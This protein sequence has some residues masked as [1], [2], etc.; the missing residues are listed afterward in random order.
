MAFRE[1]LNHADDLLIKQNLLVGHDSVVVV[2]TEVPFA[3][4]Y[5]VTNLL[6]V[7]RGGVRF[8]EEAERVELT[9]RGGGTAMRHDEI[10]RVVMGSEV[11]KALR[12]LFLGR[13][14]LRPPRHVVDTERESAAASLVKLARKIRIIRFQNPSPDV[15]ALR[16]AKCEE[17][18]SLNRKHLPT[19]QVQN[20]RTDHMNLAAFFGKCYTH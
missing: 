18:L 8:I 3:V 19:H 6:Q 10:H 20:V 11:L 15:V 16:P 13:H 9:L 12:H 14:L 5:G 4:V 7:L 17:R 1:V 2:V